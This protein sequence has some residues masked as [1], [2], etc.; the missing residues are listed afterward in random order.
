MAEIKENAYFSRWIAVRC[1]DD[2]ELSRRVGTSMDNWGSF[3]LLPLLYWTFIR[4]RIIDTSSRAN[5]VATAGEGIA[6]SNWTCKVDTMVR[7][8]SPFTLLEAMPSRD[9]VA[10]KSAVSAHV[11][12]PCAMSFVARTAWSD[13]CHSALPNLRP[14]D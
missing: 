2:P 7:H 8:P 5:A 13:T 9:G 1:V 10:S 4:C 14:H 12:A 6:R 11:D 3:V